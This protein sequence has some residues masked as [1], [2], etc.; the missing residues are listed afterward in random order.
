MAIVGFASPRPLFA[1][2]PAPAR[3]PVTLIEAG[4]PV[5]VPDRD[6]WNRIVLLATPRFTSGDT[7]AVPDSIRTTVSRFTFTMLATVRA[8]ETPADTD[9]HELVEIGIGYSTP[10][11]G[12]LTVVAPDAVP[13]SVPLDF[14]GRQ[15][16]NAK[17]KTLTEIECVG[18][19]ATAFVL[20]A[21]TITLRGDSHEDLVVRHMVRLDPKSGGCSICI[22]LLAAG[23]DGVIA[24][25]DEPLRLVAGGTQE[26]RMIHVDGSRFMLG[27]PTKRAFALEDLP[28]GQRLDWSL[29]LRTA[30]DKPAY[31]PAALDQLAAKIDAASASLRTLRSAERSDPGEE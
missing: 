17:Q 1:E 18:A 5:D 26:E 19:H 12:Q 21:P 15:V 25:V 11:N 2:D 7:D 16:L 30:A 10:V 29:E 31:T 23:P 22:W 8:S 20:D 28:P 4:T 24:P 27:M 13:P 3:R 6:R 14:L 9:H